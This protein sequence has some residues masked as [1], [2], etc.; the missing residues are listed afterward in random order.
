MVAQLVKNVSL[1]WDLKAHDTCTH[2]P[3]A[4]F[5][6]QFN[7]VHTHLV[8]P[9]Y[10]W[11]IS[12]HLCLSLPSGILPWGLPT[13]ILYAVFISLRHAP[14]IP[15]ILSS[16]VYCLHNSR[17]RVQIILNND[18]FLRLHI[19]HLF[20]AKT[21]SLYGNLFHVAG[22]NKW[23]CGVSCGAC[24]LQSSLSSPVP[25]YLHEDSSF[26][27]YVQKIQCYSVHAFVS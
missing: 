7:P 23:E 19:A 14:H 12:S 20:D 9:M 26:S 15:P 24:L 27:W 22:W 8:S 17:W 6:S 11:I 5:L 2:T 18:I 16:M 4:S 21:M 10:C 3:L 13:R 1:L 25:H